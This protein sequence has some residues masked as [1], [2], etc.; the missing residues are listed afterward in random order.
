MPPLGVGVNLAMLDACELALALVRSPS[1]DAAVR[2]YERSML[3]RS[4]EAA[5]LLEHGVGGLL[6]EPVPEPAPEPVPE[7]GP[8]P[9]PLADAR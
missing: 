2:G 8:E 6:G 9:V 4:A 1:V 5:R 3:P 7:P